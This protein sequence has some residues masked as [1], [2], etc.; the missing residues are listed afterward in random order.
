MWVARSR[1]HLRSFHVTEGPSSF[2]VRMLYINGVGC[3]REEKAYQ[4][5]FDAAW[6]ETL[7]RH[8]DQITKHRDRGWCGIVAWLAHEEAQGRSSL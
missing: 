2:D 3:L 4:A 7:T 5:L 1:Q 6:L 8:P